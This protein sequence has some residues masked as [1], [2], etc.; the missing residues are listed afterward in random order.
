[1]F[2]SIAHLASL[3]CRRQFVKL[4]MFVDQ[5]FIEEI[6]QRGMEDSRSAVRRLRQY[7]QAQV[8]RIS[9]IYIYYIYF[10]YCMCYIHTY[11]I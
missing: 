9:Y 2:W 11:N 3:A 6:I 5:A 7:L 1:M 10:I 4:L 8:P